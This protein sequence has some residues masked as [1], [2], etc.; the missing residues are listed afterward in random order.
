[1]S[2]NTTNMYDIEPHVAEIY[3]NQENFTDDVELI[4]SLIGDNSPLSILE[5][6]CGTGRIFI[7][8]ALNGHIIV[9]IDSAGGMLNRAHIKIKRLPEDV[10]RRISLIKADVISKDW[11]R[12]F[13]L[14]IL[15]GNCFYELATLEEQEKCIIQA[16]TSLKSGGHVFIDNDHMEGEI[17]ISWQQSGAKQGFP[18]GKCSDGTNVESTTET[19]WF[20]IQRRLSKFRRCSKVTLPDGSI[21]EKEYIQQKHPVSAVEVK[22]WLEKHG[23]TIK[24]L[25][26]DRAGNSYTETSPRAIFWAVKE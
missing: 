11:P 18:T 3:D 23:F 26:G 4:Q 6:F 13:D 2:Y 21:I 8:L 20:D 25:F 24:Q 12:D 10:Q 17:D 15:G 14:V 5:P 7:P 1:M 9:G 16:V 22:T 19:I